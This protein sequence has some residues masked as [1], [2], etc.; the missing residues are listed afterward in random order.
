MKRKFIVML[1]AAIALPAFTL[2]SPAW[3]STTSCDVFTNAPSSFRT[4]ASGTGGRSGCVSGTTVKTDLKYN[5]SFSPDPVIGYK[6][7]TVVNVRWTPSATCSGT[8]E[9]YLDTN[10][11]TG[12]YSTSFRRT[13]SC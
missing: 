5:R 4:T 11:G 12:Q 13:L 8:K 6:S 10:S 2:L 9:Y 3:G 1:A 7:G